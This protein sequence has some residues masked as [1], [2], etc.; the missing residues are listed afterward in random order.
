MTYIPSFMNMRHDAENMGSQ[1]RGNEFINLC[2][3]LYNKGIKLDTTQ[4]FIY[5]SL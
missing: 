2:A 3:C 1:I 4:N 5:T